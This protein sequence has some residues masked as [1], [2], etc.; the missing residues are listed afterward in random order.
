MPK[1]LLSFRIAISSICG[2][3]C[4]LMIAWWVR[5]YWWLDGGFVKL[6]PSEYIQ[7]NAGDGR[8]CVWFEHKPLNKWFDCWSRANTK[9]TRPDA[10]NRIP[11]F[12]LA[13]WPT[14]ARL[15]TAHWLLAVL[16]GS[17][18]LVPW[19]P[20]RFSLRTLLVATTVIGAMAG[21]IVWVDRT[22]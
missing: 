10:E 1:L 7:F 18:A 4:L 22:F 2:V 8:M 13:F 20:K 19:C 14:F 11:W 5:S 12:N 3:C 21:L 15:Y 16:A 9:P 6:T 17:F